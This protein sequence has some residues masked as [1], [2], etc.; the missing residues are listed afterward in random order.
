MRFF[1]KFENNLMYDKITGDIR[2]FT[3]NYEK[4]DPGDETGMCPSFSGVILQLRNGSGG[5]IHDDGVAVF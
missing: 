2:C 5:A 3:K 4:E 1:V